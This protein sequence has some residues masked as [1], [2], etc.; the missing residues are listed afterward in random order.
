[1][2][3]RIFI[4]GT[5]AKNE[6]IA[7]LSYSDEMTFEEVH[8]VETIVLGHIENILYNRNAEAFQHETRSDSFMIRCEING[9]LSLH[10]L[11]DIAVTIV[12]HIPLGVECKILLFS[13]CLSTI[14]VALLNDGKYTIQSVDGTQSIE[15]R[16]VNRIQEEKIEGRQIFS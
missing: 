3:K 4:G 5:M 7:I 10:F 15:H 11:Q 13:S 6:L 8:S 9:M 12:D 1:M 14:K 2:Y 16:Q